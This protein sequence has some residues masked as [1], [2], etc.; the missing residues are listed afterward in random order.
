MRI[1]LINSLLFNLNKKSDELVVI[2]I[3]KMFKY[4][5]AALLMAESEA[6]KTQSASELIQQAMSQVEAGTEAHAHLS[7]ALSATD[8]KTA[9]ARS[10]T[11][12]VPIDEKRALSLTVSP[13]YALDTV[14]SV[15]LK[16]FRKI[17]GYDTFESIRK[18]DR[19]EVKDASDYYN[20]TVS[21]MVQRKPVALSPAPKRDP[22]A[23]DGAPS[24]AASLD[25]GFPYDD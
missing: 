17:V 7:A 11:F 19:A 21:M 6:V 13:N 18:K 1:G 25:K 24:L 23:P 9:A 10:Q 22:Y 16:A 15:T 5:L 12:S 8:A 14:N 4:A 2:I 3:N 20:V